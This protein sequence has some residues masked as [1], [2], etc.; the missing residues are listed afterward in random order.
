MPRLELSAAH[1]GQTQ[2]R[3]RCSA[4]G[5][6]QGGVRHNSKMEFKEAEPIMVSN[7]A[8]A[9]P[10]Y[11]PSAIIGGLYGDG[12]ISLKGAFSREWAQRMRED[13][14]VEIEQAHSIEGLLEGRG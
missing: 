12:I 10:V 9:G 5:P 3:L 6:H 2:V 14:L 13:M 8:P 1:R 4:P 11:D 7:V